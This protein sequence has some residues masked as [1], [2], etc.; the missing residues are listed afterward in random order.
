MLKFL[1]WKF[2]PNP[3]FVIYLVYMNMGVCKIPSGMKIS[4]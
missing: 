1:Y 4:N 2:D 3:D